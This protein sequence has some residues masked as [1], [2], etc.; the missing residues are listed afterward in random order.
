[1]L[2]GAAAA[3]NFWLVSPEPAPRHVRRGTAGRPSTRTLLI[4]SVRAAVKKAH[5]NLPIAAVA[6]Q[7][8][9]KRRFAQEKLFAMVYSWFGGVALVIAAVGLCSV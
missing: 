9:K 2:S 1:M 5:L 7:A 8:E 3:N 4:Y 6:T